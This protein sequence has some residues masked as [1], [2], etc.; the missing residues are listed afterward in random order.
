MRFINHRRRLN[1]LISNIICWSEGVCVCRH[2]ISNKTYLL[3]AEALEDDEHT[4]DD[5]IVDIQPSSYDSPF[6]N[7]NI[8]NTT[9]NTTTTQ[10]SNSQEFMVH[11]TDSK[12]NVS[13]MKLKR[14]RTFSEPASTLEEDVVSSTEREEDVLV[15]G[16]LSSS[17]LEFDLKHFESMGFVDRSLDIEHLEEAGVENPFTF[18]VI[19]NSEEESS[20]EQ[21]KQPIEQLEDATVNA[22]TTTSS[23]PI[24]SSTATTDVPSLDDSN[25]VVDDVGAGIDTTDLLKLSSSGGN[26]ARLRVKEFV[27]SVIDKDTERTSRRNNDLPDMNQ[28]KLK[29]LRFLTVTF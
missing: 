8:P 26:D 22:E 24:T 15:P 10:R 3:L 27:K 11:S 9:D 7:T 21:T 17:P 16:I 6:A 29:M 14:M 20:G 5:S 2:C 25:V 28:V 1:H 13:P 12:G 23:I 18:A 19:N 4:T